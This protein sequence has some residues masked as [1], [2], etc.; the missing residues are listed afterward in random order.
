MRES[1]LGVVRETSGVVTMV[2][3][4]SGGRLGLSRENSSLEISGR[5]GRTSGAA[6]PALEVLLTLRLSKTN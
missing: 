4:T 5:Q 2:R 3:E 1:G 6:T